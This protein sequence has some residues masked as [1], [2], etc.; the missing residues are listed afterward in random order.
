MDNIISSY[1]TSEA[2]EDGYLVEI[3]KHRWPELTDSKP[4]LATRNVFDNISLAG[5]MEIWNEYVLK[6]KTQEQKELFVTE[7]NNKKVWV[8]D[9]GAVFTIL[10]PEDY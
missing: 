6:A 9:D 7:M 2:V 5:I 1:T 3:L 8:I 4:L 10:Y